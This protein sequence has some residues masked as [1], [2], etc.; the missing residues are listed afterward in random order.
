MF[1]TELT[2][3]KLHLPA[4]TDHK[5]IVL[6]GSSI[7][8]KRFAY[9]I[10]AEFGQQV[11][12]WYEFTGEALNLKSTSKSE[13]IKQ[14][15]SQVKQC[16]AKHYRKGNIFSA[17]LSPFEII[18]QKMQL[19]SFFQ[20]YTLEEKRIFEPEI[21][22][23][24]KQAHLQPER[25]TKP[26][27]QE[28]EFQEKLKSHNAYFL[29]TL[30][31]PIY[32]AQVLSSIQGL[33]INQHAGH[34]PQYKGSYTTEWELYHRDMA[35]ISSTVHITTAQADAGAILRRSHPA[36]SVTD[37]PGAIFCKVV[38]LGT[39]LMIDA[40]KEIMAN[41]TIEIYPQPNE[42]KTYLAKDFTDDIAL[43]IARDFKNNLFENALNNLR[44]Y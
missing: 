36:I 27:L 1:P 40:V 24:K 41:K 14:L 23:L 3:E 8:H 9:R 43:A 18:K 15:L 30:G 32:P 10:Q 44:N 42:G 39:E 20:Q 34:S 33:C 26:M 19:R 21:N 35:H 12:A 2:P 13:K 4:S 28:L 38:A 31:G 6:T 7:R 5:I 22:R 11:C 17:L 16:A 25:V 37:H 29:L